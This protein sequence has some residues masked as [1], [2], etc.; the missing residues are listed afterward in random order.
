MAEM[1]HYTLGEYVKLLEEKGMLAEYDLQ[2]KDGEEIKLLTYDSREVTQGTLFICKGAAFKAE[3]LKNSMNQGAVCYVSEKKYELEKEV[4]YILVKGIRDAMAV[5][6]NFFYNKPWE[7]LPK[8]SKIQ[9]HQTAF[10]LH[11]HTS[12]PVKRSPSLHIQCYSPAHC[13]DASVT[14]LPPV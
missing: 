1:K 12:M 14:L 13:A 2:G 3:Y 5:L 9:I 6:A 10:H 8:Y 11:D 7:D 4:P